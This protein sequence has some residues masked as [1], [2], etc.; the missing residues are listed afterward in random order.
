MKSNQSAGIK[1]CE[2]DVGVTERVAVSTA[3][4]YFF[5]M[6]SLFFLLLPEFLGMSEIPLSFLDWGKGD[7]FL[8]PC[9]KI[10]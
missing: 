1:K 8:L 6:V 4:K 9:R 5:F 2:L 10:S 7:F 3:E